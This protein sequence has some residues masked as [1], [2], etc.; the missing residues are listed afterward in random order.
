MPPCPPTTSGR[1][2]ERKNV[3]APLAA[4]DVDTEQIVGHAGND[5]HFTRALRRRDILQDERVEKVVHLARRA[6]ELHLPQQLH[7]P[8]VRFGEDLLVLDPSGS[9]RVDAMVM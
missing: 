7:L 6:L 5:R 1:A 9:S 2:P 4:D 8:D 3:A